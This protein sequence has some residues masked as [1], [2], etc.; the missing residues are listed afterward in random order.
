MNIT[1]FVESLTRGGLERMVLE[2]VKVQQRE[3]HRCQVVCLFETGSLAHELD[4]IG[5][6]V[7]ACH[8]RHG[9]DLRALRRARGLI[10]AHGTEVLHTHN[11]VAHYQAVLSSFGLGLRHVVNT[12]HGM[13]NGRIGDRREW[14]YRKALWR[15]DV[16]VSVCDAAYRDV[17][18]RGVVPRRLARVVPNGIRLE[19]FRAASAAMR[20]RLLQSLA[21]PPHT[22]VI[23]SV[24]RLNWA[25]DQASLIRAFRRVHQQLPD[26]VLVVVGDGNRRTRLEQCAQDEGV[27]HRVRLLGDRDDVH[28]LLQ[29]FDLFALSSLSEGYSI[30]LLEACAV[31]LP[32]VAT[33]VG[34]NGEIVRDG[35][36]GR[37]VT[38]A[39]PQALAD[40][41]LEL[42]NDP[43]RAAE[44]G[45][46]ARAW[47]E[48]N[49]TLETMTARY[50]AI[51][52]GEG[53]CA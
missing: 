39:D 40:A 3:G 30:A 31:C 32:I 22:R 5:V 15:T 6:P 14:L 24:G 21:L 20:E 51:Y 34:G 37:L 19:G 33:D 46:A 28:A 35:L 42:L 9:L 12:R 16:V 10:R 26:T 18:Q 44:M 13:D 45:R 53:S 41:M 17:T 11:A 47:L 25:K 4:D 8:K 49:G 23:G 48:Q 36:T 7:T 27:A 38:P 43:P 29:G 1:H 2:L 52:R 50:D